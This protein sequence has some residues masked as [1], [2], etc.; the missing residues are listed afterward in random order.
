M[1][2][3][4]AK[5]VQKSEFSRQAILFCSRLIIFSLLNSIL[6]NILFEYVHVIKLNKYKNITLYKI[7]KGKSKT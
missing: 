2:K 7:L 6:L 3:S 4:Q 1:L 5:L